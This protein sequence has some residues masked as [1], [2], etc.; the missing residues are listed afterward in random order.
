VMLVSWFAGLVPGIL[1]AAMCTLALALFWSSAKR[2]VVHVSSDLILFSVVALAICMVIESLRRA[3]RQADAAARSREDVLAVVAHDLRT[4]L[5][6]IRMTSASLQQRLP[7]ADPMQRALAAVDRSATRMENLIRDLVDATRIEHGQFQ[8]TI[9]DV[10]LDTLVHE[11]HDAFAPLA[12]SKGLRFQLD[13][14]S[15]GAPLRCDRDRMLQ[16][17]GNLLGNSLRFT[18][19]GGS[20]TLKAHAGAA[21]VRFEVED[22]GQGI[23]ATDLP[24]IFD[25]YWNTDRQGSGL[26]L[27]I[28]RSIVRAHGGEIEV[29]STPGHGSSF[30]FTLPLRAAADQTSA[31]GR[32]RLRR[33]RQLGG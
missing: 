7:A 18:P 24:H 22:S 29:K 2:G 21:G 32:F 33:L 3:R 14:Q 8:L 17:L 1:S 25:R 19:Q 4:P 23:P 13:A 27:F 28:A 15:G 30:F 10:A 5:T 20:I 16:V 26:G 6:T 11:A 12:R 9:A 31:S